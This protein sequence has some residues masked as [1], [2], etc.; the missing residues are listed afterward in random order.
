MAE[1]LNQLDPDNDNQDE[2]MYT[3][4]LSNRKKIIS[5]TIGLYATLTFLMVVTDFLFLMIIQSLI[6]VIAGVMMLNYTSL[7]MTVSNN[8][9]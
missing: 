3:S 9:K 5:I 8:G 7:M 6:Q 1:I 4:K 2:I